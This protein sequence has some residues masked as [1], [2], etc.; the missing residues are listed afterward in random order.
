VAFF[1]RAGLALL[2]AFFAGFLAADFLDD[3]FAL[4]DVVVL[5]LFF[6]VDVFLTGMGRSSL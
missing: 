2:P 4:V 3:A 1:A 6:R 5:E